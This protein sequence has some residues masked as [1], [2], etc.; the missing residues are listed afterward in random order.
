MPV[1][2]IIILG[3]DYYKGREEL[4]LTIAL[5]IAWVIIIAII[6]II[7]VIVSLNSKSTQKK[8]KRKAAESKRDIKVVTSEHEKKTDTVWLIVLGIIALIAA[9]SSIF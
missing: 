1:G 8:L 7:D 2:V 5:W 3:E 4:W 6:G 9:L